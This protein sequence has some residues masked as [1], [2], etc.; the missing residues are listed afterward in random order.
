MTRPA[1]V[2][3]TGRNLAV[4]ALK[5]V[6]AVMVVAIHVD[7]LAPL[8]RI[9]SLLTVD[10]IYRVAVPVFLIF[11][12][13]FMAPALTAGKGWAVVRRAALLYATWM[14]IYTPI[15]APVVADD[16][17]PQVL[18]FLAFGYLQLWYLSGLAMAAALMVLL[19]RMPNPALAALAL[20][21]LATGTALTLLIATGA[22]TPGPLFALPISPYRNG[23]VL[24]FPYLAIGVLMARLD[25]PARVPRPAA[26]AVVTA[27]L[28]LLAVETLAIGTLPVSVLHDSLGSLVLLA[29]ALALLALQS[30]ART[31]SRALADHASGLFFQHMFL[32]AVLRRN[33]DLNTT[34]S[35][36]LTIAGCVLLTE[37][38]RRT[39]LVRHLF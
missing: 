4:D 6:M 7:P 8:G 30:P 11:N 31:A 22:W 32:V 15:W 1:T 37:A 23:L 34:A 25:L 17:V 21:L 35:F 5:L 28:V 3:D 9:V 12:G 38:L 27:G 33:T 39:R 14:L 26:W 20:L 18:R 29:P 19:N 36:L 2:P 24:C 10:G 16:S 13:W